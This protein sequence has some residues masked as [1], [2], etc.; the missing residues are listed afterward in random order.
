MMKAWQSGTNI[1]SS[2][3]TFTSFLPC[4]SM[5]LL[6]WLVISKFE[7]LKEPVVAEPVMIPVTVEPVLAKMA[8]TCSRISTT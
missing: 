2:F 4:K 7:E 6:S 3:S 8:M 5:K 1:Y